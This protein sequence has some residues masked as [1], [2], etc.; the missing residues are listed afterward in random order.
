MGFNQLLS[1]LPAD[2]VDGM[3]YLLPTNR[4]GLMMMLFTSSAA[5]L[6]KAAGPTKMGEAMR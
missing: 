2:R 5:K 4:A 3:M 1:T 6:P